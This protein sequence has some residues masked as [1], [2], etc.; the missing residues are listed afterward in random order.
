MPR[1]SA[2]HLLLRAAIVVLFIVCFWRRAPFPAYADEIDFLSPIETW[3]KSGPNAH[4]LWHSPVYVSV[5]MWL[6]RAFGVSTAVFR[7]IGF[8]SIS[9]AAGLLYSAALTLRP[10]LED[11]RKTLLLGLVLLSPI[12]LGASLLLDYDTTM[13]VAATSLYFYLLVRY[14]FEGTRTM[15][16]PS[17]T[18]DVIVFGVALGLCLL[19]KETTPLVYPAGLMLVIWERTDSF[20]SAF[21]RS[22]ASAVLGCLIFLS[23]AGLWCHYYSLPLS[24]VFAM[25]VL[26][27][28]IHGIET[29]PWRVMSTGAVFWLKS[30]PLA[31]LGA[32]VGV[33]FFAKLPTLFRARGAVRAI[34]IVMLIVLFVYSVLLSQA[35][36]H[37]PKYMSPV[38]L[39]IYWLVLV[40]EREGLGH[41]NLTQ[42][43][44][45]TWA[46]GIL[47]WF[48]LIPVDPMR[49]VYERN[50]SSFMCFALVVAAPTVIWALVRYLHLT[51]WSRGS[52]RPSTLAILLTMGLSLAYC[53]NALLT[54][55]SIT[56]WYGDVA[57]IETREVVARW[58]MHHPN[59][60]VY[61]PSKDMAWAVRDLAATYIQRENLGSHAPEICAMQ[62]PFLVV[63]RIREDSSL[64]RWPD[65]ESLRKCLGPMREGVDIVYAS[66]YSRD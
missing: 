50:F 27:L 44:F 61:I 11:W 40:P 24:A 15:H 3:V 8:V 47:L 14:S 33:L 30:M 35:T 22:V 34:A 6:G 20:A 25:D 21:A 37:F 7:S 18:R 9:C 48:I 38:L 58:R 10:D 4:G 45:R 39:W 26:G 57:P 42:T 65:F 46:I 32:P 31:W 51:T 12:A 55:G 29:A 49:F 17:F 54:N 16:I 56:Y 23:F 41:S 52:P 13:L 62:K 63:T 19:A 60:A 28:N 66:A 53:R 1:R 43:N 59:G 36:Y 5:L 64:L 2:I